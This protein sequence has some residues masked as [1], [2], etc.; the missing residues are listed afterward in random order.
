MAEFLSTY[1]KPTPIFS[2][3]TLVDL[4]MGLV[5]LVMTKYNDADTFDFS[6]LVNY[7]YQDIISLVYFRP[8]ENPLY[9]FLTEYTD[10]KIEFVDK[11]YKEFKETKEK[12]IIDIGVITEIPNLIS[13]YSKSGGMKP[14]IFYYNEDQLS[15]LNEMTILDH[16]EK[17]RVE[18]ISMNRFSQFYLMDCE[19]AEFIQTARYKTIYFASHQ[20]NMDRLEADLKEDKTLFTLLG[21]HNQ[22][23]IFDVYKQEIINKE[24]IHGRR[25]EE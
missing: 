15:L 19:E 12:D 2:F 4:D 1:T 11:C 14:V 23:N 10:E 18:D 22:F 8:M 17:I 20:R 9:P 3:K 16:I 25:I 7:T 21:N 5:N 24:N 13:T 6:P